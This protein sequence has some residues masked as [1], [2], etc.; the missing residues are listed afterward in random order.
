MDSGS[1]IFAPM[2]S[3]RTFFVS[4]P[5]LCAIVS[6]I[7]SIVTLIGGLPKAGIEDIYFLR[8]NTTDFYP[9]SSS[10]F[11][12]LINTV[13]ADLGL[14]NYYQ[15]SLWN[16]CS[17]D[18]KNSS[19]TEFASPTYCSPANASYWFDP[20]AIIQNSV[21]A[22]VTFTVPE[23]TVDDL[24]VLKTAQTWLK[25]LLIVGTCF[26]FLTIFACIFAY[27]S[28]VASFLATLV[29]F[30]GALFT[31]VAA[32]L[33]QILGIIVRNVING[34]TDINLKATLG[35]KFYVLIWI[36]AGFALVYWL[37]ITFTIC[38]CVPDRASRR[39]AKQI[40]SDGSDVT[41]K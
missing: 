3:A 27:R 23:S 20:I 1:P 18:L 13:A 5:I 15:T 22:V 8:I 16:Y 19:T 28:R 9:N 11:A 37:T 25:A 24:K 32:V 30:I 35:K 7:L 4:I 38:C 21:P 39:K 2:G 14:E 10:P 40:R 41:E 33:A 34:L 6:L 17:G 31:V 12:A 29:A 26:S 36:A